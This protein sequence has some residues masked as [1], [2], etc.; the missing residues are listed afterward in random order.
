MFKKLIVFVVCI[1]ATTCMFAQEFSA[2]VRI[3][4]PSLQRADRKVF[5]ALESSIKEF[6]NTNK[7]TED[8]YDI[9]E[10]IKIN[11]TITIN[12]EIGD[13]TFGAEMAIQSSRPVFQSGYETPL[14]THFDKDFSFQ[15]D[16]FQPLQFSKDAIDNNLTAVLGFY[17]YV[18][19]AADYDSYAPLGGDQYVLAA[20]QVLNNIP[21]AMAAAFS[22][23]K[24]SD[25]G[26]NRN[27]F[28]IVE[29]LISPRIRPYRSSIYLYHRKGLDLMSSDMVKAREQV[30]LA[31]EEVDK[32]NNAYINSMI[33]S[34]FANAKR[35]ELV[36]MW[37]QG[38]RTQRLRVYEIMTKIDP[39]SAQRYREMGL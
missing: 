8:A 21:P 28:W 4:T 22:G 6:Y 33:L 3:N 26:K 27:R 30:L 23:W 18:I 17:A 25:G 10:R 5:D 31:L 35:D 39:G 11:I 13:N 2:S 7:F 38:E 37:K 9:D 15:Y 19:L 12:N 24:T 29:N 20:Q 14:L 1:F 32:V 36:E 34:M 16:I